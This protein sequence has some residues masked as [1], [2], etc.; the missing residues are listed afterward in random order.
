[1]M[2]EKEYNAI[3]EISNFKED[4]VEPEEVHLNL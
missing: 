1:M 2:Q 3:G 4:I